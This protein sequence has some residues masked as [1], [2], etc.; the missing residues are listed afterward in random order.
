[1]KTKIFTTIQII[2]GIMLLT[3]GLNTFLHFIPMPAA[4]QEMGA[5]TGA[6][7]ATGFIFPIVGLV[8]TLAGLAFI[9]NKFSALMAIIITPI[10][11]NAFLAHL[12]L[13]PAGIAGSLIILVG[14]VVVMIRNKERYK[15]I[16]QV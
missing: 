14:I 7:F 11:L 8:E 5:Y 4:S 15:T 3:F 9:T 2:S 1:M 6:L 10:M 16:F 12:F 13:D